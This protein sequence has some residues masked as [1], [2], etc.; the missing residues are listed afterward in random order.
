MNKNN[1]R[2][3][4]AYFYCVRG[5]TGS[6]VKVLRSLVAQLSWSP[7]G[8]SLAEAVQS[9]YR[10]AQPRSPSG[11]CRPLTKEDCCQLIWEELAPQFSDITI[12]IDALDECRDNDVLLSWL[13]DIHQKASDNC[14]VKILLSSRNGVT[15]P[16]KFPPCQKLDLDKSP[17]LTRDDLEHFIET[18]VKGRDQ[19]NLGRRLLDGENEE[20]EERLMNALMAGHHGA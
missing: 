12:I 16:S 11:D 4:L 18:E 3:R 14:R 19:L 10:Q 7:D 17:D 1:S 13:L 5:R 20:L 8:C 2:S 15:L 9:R 6:A